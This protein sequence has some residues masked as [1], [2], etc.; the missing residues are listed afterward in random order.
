MFERRELAQLQVLIALDAVGGAD[1]REHFGLLDGID[2]E[3]GLE[4]QVHLQHVRRI[5]GLL[6]H[7]LD[8]FP[9]DAV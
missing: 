9:L 7:Q 3:V 2:T 6:G 4:V 1:R 8:D 5:T